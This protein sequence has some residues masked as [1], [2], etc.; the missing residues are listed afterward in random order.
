MIVAKDLLIKMHFRLQIGNEHY[1]NPYL[2]TKMH[3]LPKKTLKVNS[4]FE[5]IYQHIYIILAVSILHL[6]N[7]DWRRNAPLLWSLLQLLGPT[8]EY[9]IENPGFHRIHAIIKSCD[10]QIHPIPLDEKGIDISSL[11]NTNSNVA[12]VTPSHQ[13][14]LGIIM[15][16]SRRLEL[17]KWANNCGG[18]IIED[19]YDGEF[20]YAGKP[21]PSLQ[22]L[23]SN[24]RVIYMGTFSKSFYL[25]YEWDMLF[26][27]H[28][29]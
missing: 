24:E 19:D 2:H 11:Y 20:R 13:F 29:F 22:S 7:C 4:L 6:I 26:Y 23:D 12:Y 1:K 25:L 14:P 9:G 10:R 5:S 3:Y 17:L 27:H 8:K 21:I 18:Y 15:P 28:T 16:L